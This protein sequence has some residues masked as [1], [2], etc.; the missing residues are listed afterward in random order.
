MA[1]AP[2]SVSEVLNVSVDE[3]R[4]WDRNPRRI[5]QAALDQ[6]AASLLADPEMLRARPIIALPDGRVIAGN[7]RLRV[8]LELGWPTVPTVYADLDEHTAATWALRDNNPY[9]EWDEPALADLLNELR[10]AQVD[11]GLTGFSE[12]ALDELLATFDGDGVPTDR[13]TALALAD[14]SVGDPR[15]ECE[16]GHTYR[17]GPHVLVVTSVYDGWPAWRDLLSPDDLF[18]PY[19]TPTLPLTSRADRQRLVMVQPDTWLAG[20]VLDKYAAVHGEDTVGPA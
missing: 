10:E 13:G 4:L 9:G 16:A 18:V 8:A 1:T 11:L 15:H 7:M 19:P 14:V 2:A 17:V 3:L 12:Q 6:L 20:H 5:S